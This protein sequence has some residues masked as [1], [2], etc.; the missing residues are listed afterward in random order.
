[1]C[2][3]WHILGYQSRCRLLNATQVGGSGDQDVVLVVQ[4]HNSILEG[5]HW[6]TTTKRSLRPMINCLQ[7]C[8]IPAAAYHH[9]T[10]TTQHVSSFISLKPIQ[11]TVNIWASSTQELPIRRPTHGI[12]QLAPL[13]GRYGTAFMRLLKERCEPFQGEA[14]ENTWQQSFY[15]NTLYGSS[16]GQGLVFKGNDGITEVLLWAHCD[17]FLISRSQPQEIQRGTYRIP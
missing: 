15:T 7:S 6:P 4:V 13:A 11:K 16:L 10:P 8:G 17:A 5:R 12:L 1:M 14:S 3:Q 9:N 2:T